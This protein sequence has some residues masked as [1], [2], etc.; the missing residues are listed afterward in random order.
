M[1]SR[2]PEPYSPEP[3]GHQREVGTG[4]FDAIAGAVSGG[5]ASTLALA[6]STERQQF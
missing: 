4:V 6:G 5:T 2:N 3:S 1:T